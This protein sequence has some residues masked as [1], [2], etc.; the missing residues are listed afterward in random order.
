MEHAT[1]ENRSV[2]DTP[3]CH[4]TAVWVKMN[5]GVPTN[6]RFCKDCGPWEDERGARDAYGNRVWKRC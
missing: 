1:E 4:K 6:E 5:A 2:C 3:G